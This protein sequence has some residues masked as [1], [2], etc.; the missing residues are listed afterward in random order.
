M[1]FENIIVQT[2]NN[3]ATVTI[4]RP[5][6]MN[7]LNPSVL[8]ELIVAF[9]ELKKDENLRGV[10]LTGSGDKAFVAGADITTMQNMTPM[11]AKGFVELGH[12]CMRAI[13]TFKTP[14][15][16]AVNGFAL[17]GGLELALSCDFI[18]ASQNAKMGLPEVNLGIFPGFGGTQR[19]GRVIG[20]NRAK[21]LTY[22]AK[23]ISADEAF[24][25]GLV[26]KVTTPETL[27]EEVKKTLN[28][29]SQKGPVAVQLVK[30]VINEGADLNL[31]SGLEMEALAFP[32]VFSTEDKKEGI[33]AFL[34]KRPAKFLG[35]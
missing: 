32:I 1:N 3:I 21:E 18:Y 6:A 28:T 27:L 7:A 24:Q 15:I 4:N 33:T 14:V 12:E 11:Q 29:I 13:E 20:R 16:A 8:S 23:M 25:M 30:Q 2:E 10:I 34:E 35:K 31:E 19:L 22:T 17:G 26:N 5:K 9:G